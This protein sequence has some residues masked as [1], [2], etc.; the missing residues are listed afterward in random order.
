MLLSYLWSRSFLTS[1][2][3]LWL[4][5]WCNLIGTVYGYI[6]YG[7]QLEY[8]LS[9]HPI[10]Q[11]VF[12]PDS[13]T[14]SLFFTISVF[15]LL[16]PP[17]LKGLKVIRQLMEALAVVTSVKYG[18]WASAIIFFGCRAGRAYDM[19]GLDAGSISYG[20]GSRILTVRSF[21]HLQMDGSVRSSFV[22]TVK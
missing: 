16:Y 3:F 15:F 4:L 2:P 8:T 1:R 17:R 12:V 18:I 5:F 20:N 19:A 21:F 22:D 6:W 11:I 13:P 14:A 7:G 9:Y 10:W